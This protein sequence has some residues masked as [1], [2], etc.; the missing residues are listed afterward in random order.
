VAL[1]KI[2]PDLPSIRLS[3]YLEDGTAGLL[4]IKKEGGTVIIQDPQDTPYNDM[5]RRAL[6]HVLPDYVLPHKDIAATLQNLTSA[7][8]LPTGPMEAEP[9]YP[10]IYDQVMDSPGHVL[11]MNRKAKSK[12]TLDNAL[13]SALQA[14][15]EKIVLHQ[16]L[17]RMAEQ[18]HQMHAVR[19]YQKVIETTAMHIQLIKETLDRASEK[20]QP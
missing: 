16:E 13:W 17:L 6:E 1:A 15:N 11:P 19:K 7:S 3:G 18:Q 10:V 5:P 2:A 14:L 9:S 20:F 8:A 12:S 4:A